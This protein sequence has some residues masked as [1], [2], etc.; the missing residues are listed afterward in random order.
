LEINQWSP[1]HFDAEKSHTGQ[2]LFFYGTLHFVIIESS[3]HIIF[4]RI[5]FL[6]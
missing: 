5:I 1:A 4:V 6:L 3:V 2:F